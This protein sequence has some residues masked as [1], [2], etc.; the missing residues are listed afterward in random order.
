MTRLPQADRFHPVT[1]DLADSEMVGAAF[2]T[3]HSEAG[4]FDVLINNAGGGHF[5]PT[6]TVSPS[7]VREQ[8]QSLVFAQ[9]QLCQFASADMRRRGAGLI[10]NVTS[11]AARMPVPF[12]GAYNAAKAAM[13]SFTMSLQLESENSAIRFVDVQPGDIRTSF[14]DGV[15]RDEVGVSRRSERETQVWKIV[16]ETMQAAPPPELV[17]RHIVALVTAGNPPPQ[18]TVGDAFQSIVAPAIYRL[19]PQRTRVWGLRKYYRL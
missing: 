17:A 9:L 10:I 7:I 16:D 15:Q 6:E 2:G 11:L 19:L 5:D 1:L 4:N 14:N 13:A 18:I 8:F 12:M 3:A